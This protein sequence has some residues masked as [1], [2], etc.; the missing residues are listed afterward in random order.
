MRTAAGFSFRRAGAIV[1]RHLY[2]MR[3]SWPRV[4]ELTYW[5]TLN[6][7][8]WG[9]VTQ[10]FM[11]HS[12]WVVRG[13]GVLIASVLLWDVLFRGQ[14]GVTVPFLEELWSRNLAN[15]FVSPLHPSELVAGLVVMSIVR[16]AIGIGAA[17]L[18]AIPLYSYSIFDMGLPL[19]AFYANLLCMGWATGLMLCGLLL[20]F[21]L[22]AE[23]LAWVA[24][25]AIAP[26]TGIYYPISTLPTWLQPVALLLPAA[27]VF[28]GM[29][30]VMFDGTFRLDF[31]FAAVGLNLVYLAIGAILFLLAFRSARERGSLLQ[32]SE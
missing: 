28:E 3:G 19:L 26:L 29:R 16:T 1:L 31:F 21:G 27:H 10:F 25:F 12:A 18:L 13:A 30:A 17:A 4:L 7:I 11:T 24:I 32:T 20:R 6:M 9:F 2:L 14:L 8:V 23:S 5:P 22:G 15:L